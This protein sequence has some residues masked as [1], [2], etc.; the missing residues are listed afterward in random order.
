MHHGEGHD[1]EVAYLEWG[2]GTDFVEIDG[3][4]AGVFVLREAVRHVVPNV[5]VGTQVVHAAYVVVVVVGDEYAV[6]LAERLCE[7]LLAEVGSAV[8]EQACGGSL[9]KCRAAQPLVV[10]V[11][12]STYVALATDDW[13]TATGACS[14]ECKFH[15]IFTSG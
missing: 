4:H 2:V 6:N 9:D 10:R 14:E 11:D 12:A 15:I 1:V 7:D 8:D 13:Y 3:W 5:A